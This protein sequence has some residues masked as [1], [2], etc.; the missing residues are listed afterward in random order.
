MTDNWCHY[1]HRALPSHPLYTTSADAAARKL[2][3]NPC[4]VA[5]HLAWHKTS[6]LD[7]LV[8]RRFH[9]E[10]DDGMLVECVIVYVGKK[11]KGGRFVP[12]AWYVDAKNFTAD[13]TEDPNFKCKCCSADLSEVILFC[14]DASLSSTLEST[15]SQRLERMECH[16]LMMS[17][18]RHGFKQDPFVLEHKAMDAE[19]YAEL[20]RRLRNMR[21]YE[22]RSA[23]GLAYL[24]T[25]QM[26]LVQ[27]IGNEIHKRL[28]F[29]KPK[30]MR[31]DTG[32][33]PYIITL[34]PFSLSKNMLTLFEALLCFAGF[35][36]AE[37]KKDWTWRP[38]RC[39]LRAVCVCA[40]VFVSGR[41]WSRV[42][43]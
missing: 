13:L 24:L 28:R 36:V 27:D 16:F 11:L 14:A 26:S 40:C 43:V 15:T 19:W 34:E 7:D 42:V 1:G 20:K 37:G 10:D 39:V 25:E 6:E 23:E 17:S 32:Y 5:P 22:A 3:R 12:S 4:V 35:R 2:A 41:L 8:G 30:R 18:S 29:E 38:L 9:E 21:S 33:V 31:D